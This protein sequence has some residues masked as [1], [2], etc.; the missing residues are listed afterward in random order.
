LG[1]GEQLLAIY[2]PYLNNVLEVKP[3]HELDW[4]LVI[5]ASIGI[6]MMIEAVKYWGIPHRRQNQNAG[7]DPRVMK[8]LEALRS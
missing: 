8:P 6:L 4:L 2:L 7:A 1:F 3:L 5:G